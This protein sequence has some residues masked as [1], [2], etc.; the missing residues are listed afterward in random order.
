MSG[1]AEKAKGWKNEK[2]IDVKIDGGDN[3][4]LRGAAM[5]GIEG[6]GRISAGAWGQA[7]AAMLLALTL[8][9]MALKAGAWLIG[10]EWG[11]LEAGAAAMGIAAI[12]A[13]IGARMGS[14]V[15]ERMVQ[16]LGRSEN[17]ERAEQVRARVRELSQKAGIE[18]A[19]AE[20]I[21]EERPM[22]WSAGSRRHA[23]VLVSEGMME[24]WGEA[25]LQAALAHELA[26]AKSGD[27]RS[28]GALS[29]AI[30]A[31]LGVGAGAPGFA[32]GALAGRPQRG[33]SWMMRAPKRGMEALLGR[34]L[35]EQELRADVEAARML[36]E[37]ESIRA[38][39][40]RMEQEE[41]KRAG[42]IERMARPHPTRGQRRMNLERWEAQSKGAEAFNRRKR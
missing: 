37:A 23:R 31:L 13:I 18:R 24:S 22:A 7:G 3:R 36:G 15:A 5:R 30:G 42:L 8:A 38:A 41:P 35:R 12:G 17:S 28:R 1:G 26:H 9:A 16:S 25:E 11:W 20:L 10:A 4:G 14:P 27:M 40:E 2:N 19:S 34:W 39:V 6:S 21:K 29:G 33:A 32:L